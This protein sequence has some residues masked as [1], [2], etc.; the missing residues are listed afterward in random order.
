MSAEKTISQKRKNS[1]KLT[2]NDSPNKEQSN[3]GETRPKVRR[4]YISESKTSDGNDD[5]YDRDFDWTGSMVVDVKKAISLMN[6]YPDFLEDVVDAREYYWRRKSGIYG[7]DFNIIWRK[8]KDQI[9]ALPK[10][11]STEVPTGVSMSLDVGV[12]ETNNITQGSSRWDSLWKTDAELFSFGDWDSINLRSKHAAEEIE[13]T[14]GDGIDHC[15][16]ML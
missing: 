12:D 8:V 4:R 2:T 13:E 7:R 10:D 9:E 11:S 3:Q 14:E 6:E 15:S 1:D 5:V 16:L